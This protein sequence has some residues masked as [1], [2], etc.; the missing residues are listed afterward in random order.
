MIDDHSVVAQVPK[1]TARTSTDR[2]SEILARADAAYASDGLSPEPSKRFRDAEDFQTMGAA[3]LGS[4]HFVSAS[5][6]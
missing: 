1:G 3:I 5:I 2:D 4:Q 6:P